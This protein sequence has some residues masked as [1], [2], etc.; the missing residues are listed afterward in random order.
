MRDGRSKGLTTGAAVS[1]GSSDRRA[2]IRTHTRLWPPPHVPEIRLHLADEAMDLWEQ[3]EEQL[4]EIGLPPPF[5]AFAW[6]GGQALARYLLDHPETVAGKRV[7]DFAS[8]CGLV[9]IAAVK[10]GAASATATE[11]DVF[12]IDAIAL[13]A[14]A[15]G[16][17]VTALYEDVLASPPPPADVVLAG[18]VFYERPMS[19]AVIAWLDRAR[20]AGADVLIGDP[21]RTYLPKDRLEAVADYRVEVTRALEDSEVKHT[22][23]W[24]LKR[25]A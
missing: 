15:N 7:L 10:A 17:P 14:E 13:N 18:D 21:G 20:A 9:A 5:W 22:T 11:V 25:P 12:A 1:N 3:T 23:V 16:V 19:D 6:A 2:F 24:R 4:Q 8:G